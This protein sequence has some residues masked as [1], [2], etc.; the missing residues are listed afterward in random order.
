MCE[1]VLQ[2]LIIF[3]KNR[4]WNDWFFLIVLLLVLFMRG[5]T[6][7][8]QFKKQGT[9]VKPLVLNGQLFPPVATKSVLVFWA[10]WCG[11]CSIELN[12]IQLALDKQE[13][14]PIHIYAV[15]TGESKDV[16]NKFIN[17]QKLKIPVILDEYG[18]L[19]NLFNI[20]G[21]PTVVFIDESG[22][23]NWLS[24][25]VSPTLIYRIKNFLKD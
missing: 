19:S 3:I 9:Q 11:P 15:N 6:L 20:K 21:T 18:L 23:I 24:S 25:G 12:R 16:V 5:P 1:V 8:D 14:S 10:S 4:K 22:K 13:I 2:K 17:E 7:I